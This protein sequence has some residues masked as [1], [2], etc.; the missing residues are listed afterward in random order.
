[1]QELFA[2]SI[3]DVLLE[4][5]QAARASGAGCVDVA[6]IGAAGDRL[7]QLSDDGHGLDEP[8]SIFA[9]PLPR[10]GIFSLAGR[11][12]IVRSWSRAA[13]QGWSAHITAAAWTG[14][15]LIAI[16]PDPI[17]RGTSI[18]FR[19]PAIAEDLVRA[20]L[21]EAASLAGIVATFNGRGI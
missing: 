7:L 11:D 4:L 21:A 20:A 6:V 19:M 10:F 12:V 17:A 18:T 5:L 15:R 13:H 3:T 8:G 9:H 14:R 2:D 16:S 1:M